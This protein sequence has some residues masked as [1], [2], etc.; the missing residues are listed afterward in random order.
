M[1]TKPVHYV[2]GALLFS[3]LSSPLSTTFAQ[4]SLTPPGAPSPT[5]K[6][7]DQVE[8]RTP[9][10]SLPFAINASGSYYLTQNLN[11]TNG[12]AITITANG[13][14]LNLNGFIITSS[15]AS[16]TGTAILINGG[17]RDISI[18]N[19]YIQGGVTNNLGTYSG[20]GFANGILVGSGPTTDN[21]LISR[22]SVSGCLFFGISLRG[23]S[24]E[25]AGTVEGCA[26]KTVGQTGIAAQTVTGSSAVDCGTTGISASMV[27]NCRGDGRNTGIAGTTVSQSIGKNTGTNGI[28]IHVQS[29]A[30]NCDGDGSDGG[31]YGDFGATIVNCVGH[32]SGPPGSTGFGIFSAGGIISQ[33]RANLCSNNGIVSQGGTVSD[34]TANENAGFGIEIQFGTG[35]VGATVTGCHVQANQLSGIYVNAPGSKVAG[36]T[37]KNN[38]TANSSFHAGIF[39]NDANNRIEDN[40]IFGSGYAGISVSSFYSGNIV[41]K[42]SVQ[43]NGANNYLTPG[44]QV[45]GIIIN[46]TGT[47]TNSNPW[48]NFSF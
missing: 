27:S 48:A 5:M 16:A 20:S 9:I 30:Q 19:G 17:L 24:S 10:S 46:T 28:G 40:H 12:N 21:S 33:C 22:V 26:V 15:A 8:A 34:C 14:T 3:T 32:G 25:S 44:N 41:I 42:N 47:I 18:L 6:T 2:L 43:G 39:V 1:K 38:N 13:V 45:V 4:G 37:C 23:T 35:D 31:I 36:N 11:V 29:S 7:L